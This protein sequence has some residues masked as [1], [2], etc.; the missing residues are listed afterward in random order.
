MASQFDECPQIV[1]PTR[2]ARLVA[3]DLQDLENINNAMETVIQQS[4][5]R[6]SA[7]PFFRFVEAALSVLSPKIEINYVIGV[8]R[9]D[10]NQRPVDL[11]E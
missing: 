10:W 9:E 1:S 11:D 6:Q 5:T 2:L 8:L 7:E 3:E 4:E